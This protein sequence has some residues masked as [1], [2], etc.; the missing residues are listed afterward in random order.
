MQNFGNRRFVQKCA[1]KA[2]SYVLN[3]SK[4]ALHNH[5][6]RYLM[7]YKSL[8]KM[9]RHQGRADFFLRGGGYSKESLRSVI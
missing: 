4:Q 2:G 1:H 3:Q 5:S 8:F 9:N 6:N 7:I